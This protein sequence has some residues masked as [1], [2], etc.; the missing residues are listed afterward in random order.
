MRQAVDAVVESPGEIEPI[1][2]ALRDGPA[3][4]ARFDTIVD[5]AGH[6][7]PF[8]Q[9]DP[10]GEAVRAWQAFDDPQLAAVFLRGLFLQFGY[11]HVHD[12]AACQ[13]FL[14]RVPELPLRDRAFGMANGMIW[15]LRSEQPQGE[16]VPLE[17]GAAIGEQL[18]GPVRA[19]FFEELG[20]QGNAVGGGG[21]EAHY[22]GLREL[23]LADDDR[24]AFVHGYVRSATGGGAT[25]EEAQAWLVRS[26]EACELHVLHAAQRQ[27][28][29]TPITPGRGG[30][31]AA[32]CGFD[33]SRMEEWRALDLL[34]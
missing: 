14:E 6:L 3:D 4:P 18:V 5:I 32:R 13:A 1:V 17:L 23:D 20:W 8:D 31:F 9:A 28:C 10:E 30:D 21:H 24:C 27:R 2:A 33:G 15:G 19:L 26:S 29:G 34:P 11:D 22:T 12:P 16:T 7:F 25:L